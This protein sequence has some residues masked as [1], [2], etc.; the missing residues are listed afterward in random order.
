MT[1]KRTAKVKAGLDMTPLIDIVFLLLSF[2]MI[3]STVIKTSAINVDLPGAQTSDP[4]PMREA[5]VTLYRNGAITINDEP[6]QLDNLGKEI[7]E[8][9]I[10]NKNLVVTIRGDKGV[11]YGRLIET[12]DIVRLVG[13]KRMSLATKLKE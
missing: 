3:T 7:K 9:Y 12:M 4:Q 13:V 1:L 5:V 6:T 11:A 8:L 10:K 2:F